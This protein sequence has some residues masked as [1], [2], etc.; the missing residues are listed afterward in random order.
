MRV[1]MPAGIFKRVVV[2]HY[3]DFHG[4]AGR[5][6]FWNYIAVVIAIT[7]IAGIAVRAFSVAPARM[8][9]TAWALGCFLPTLGIAI[10]RLHDLG[11]SGW[12]LVTP[13]I[14]AFLM[15]LLFFWFWPLTVVLAACMIGS[16]WYLLY[17]CLQ[18]SMAGE[19]RYGPV[20]V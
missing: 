20:P 4:R 5:A 9:F 14:P 19:N 12:L 11:L 15:L 8:L 7:L 6:E 2:A 1:F 13:L 17:L 10:R 18:P 3:F 16:A